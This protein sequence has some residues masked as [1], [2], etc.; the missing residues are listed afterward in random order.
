MTTRLEPGSFWEIYTGR[1]IRTEKE[2]VTPKL[3]RISNKQPDRCAGKVWRL[4]L[5]YHEWAGKVAPAVCGAVQLRR[6]R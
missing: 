2:K 6:S 4:G 3:N 1:D 5:V